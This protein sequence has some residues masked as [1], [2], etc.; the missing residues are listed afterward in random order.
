MAG[1]V[2]QRRGV[3]L[4][5]RPG[6]DPEGPDTGGIQPAVHHFLLFRQ[7]EN[8]VRRSD[9]DLAVPMVLQAVEP[10][11]AAPAHA[12]LYRHSAVGVVP[13]LAEEG[14]LL[15][16]GDGRLIGRALLRQRNVFH[17]PEQL[18]RVIAGEH[19]AVGPEGGAVNRFNL[20]GVPPLKKLG[21]QRLAGGVYFLELPVPLLIEGGQP[22][23]RLH[24][25]GNAHQGVRRRLDGGEP[26][27][28][29]HG[30]HGPA[31]A[32][33]LLRGHDVQGDA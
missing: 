31:V 28:R 21:E 6:G 14:A 19:L 18:R 33:P 29:H 17:S 3:D 12:D 30:Q 22:R 24:G 5:H 9:V 16:R 13:Q 26:P 27:R 7:Q 2:V 25:A 32:G 11:I 10:G 20:H 23:L 4:H 8:E 15:Q 1:G